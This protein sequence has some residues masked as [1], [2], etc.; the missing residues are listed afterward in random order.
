MGNK[1]ADRCLE[2]YACCTNGPDPPARIEQT[3]RQVE[4]T[5]RMRRQRADLTLFLADPNR[6]GHRKRNELSA[7]YA[8]APQA[9]MGCQ[10]V[11]SS[12]TASM[13]ERASATASS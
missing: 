12:V 11:F 6:A 5:L 3:F 2:R 7:A 9:P 8:P 4:R 10:A 13:R 1:P